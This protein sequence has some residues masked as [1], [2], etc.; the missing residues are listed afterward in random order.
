LGAAPERSFQEK[1]LTWRHGSR[2]IGET[3]ATRRTGSVVG[4]CSANFALI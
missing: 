3:L 4:V 2:E 1:L